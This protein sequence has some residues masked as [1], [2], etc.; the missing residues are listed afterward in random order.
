[1]DAQTIKIEPYSKG[2]LKAIEKGII[3]SDLGFNPLNQGDYIMIKVPALTT[4]RRQELT[5]IVHKEAEE[6]KVVVRNA[7]HDARNELDK[8]FKAKEISENEKDATEKQIDELTK[9][10]NEKIEELAK[11]KA[12]EVMKV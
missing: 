6:A 1:M 10:Y 11:T 8:Q 3:E 2:D 4:E 9:K 7:R 12:E 5:K